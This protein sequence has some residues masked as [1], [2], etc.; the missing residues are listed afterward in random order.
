[1]RLVPA[2]IRGVNLIN[3]SDVA[4]CILPKLVLGVHKQK[5]SLSSLSL[6]ELKHG[7]SLFAHLI[8]W[9]PFKTPAQANED[10]NPQASTQRGLLALP[11][12]SQAT[13]DLVCQTPRPCA[14]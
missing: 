2:G 5:S 14:P 3:E 13:Y 11:I 12:Y 9:D 1:M 7:Q 4:V 6:P 8:P 10:A